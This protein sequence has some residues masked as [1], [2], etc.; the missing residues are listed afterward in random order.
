M[1][2]V[3]INVRGRAPGVEKLHGPKTDEPGVFGNGIMG[4]AVPP[5]DNGLHPTVEST[6]SDISLMP[7]F[8]FRCCQ[9]S[10]FIAASN[11][12]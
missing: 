4:Q 12:F 2:Q 10:I 5:P 3:L 9:Y 11:R 7:V 1:C 8:V 6:F